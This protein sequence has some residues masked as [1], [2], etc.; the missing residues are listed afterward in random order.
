MFVDKGELA[1]E[2]GLGSLTLREDIVS[3]VSGIFTCPTGLET[4]R[5]EVKLVRLEGNSAV[6]RSTPLVLER[7]LVET[8]LELLM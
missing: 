2:R 8:D 3:V 7:D 6:G 4:D 1:R 5:G